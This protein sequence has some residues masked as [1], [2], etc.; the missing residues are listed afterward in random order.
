MAPQFRSYVWDPALILS[1][2]MLMQAVYYSSLGLWLALVDSLVQNSPSLDQIFSYEV[3]NSSLVRHE[4]QKIF[5]AKGEFGR[6]ENKHCRLIS[7]LSGVATFDTQENP[8]A[9]FFKKMATIQ[10]PSLLRPEREGSR[11]KNTTG[12]GRKMLD[13]KKI[14]SQRLCVSV[15]HFSLSLTPGSEVEK[16]E[17]KLW[18]IQMIQEGGHKYSSTLSP[19][20]PEAGVLEVQM[21][22]WN[23]SHTC[24]ELSVNTERATWSWKSPASASPLF[25]FSQPRLLSIQTV[26]TD[27]QLLCFLIEKMERWGPCSCHAYDRRQGYKSVH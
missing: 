14:G 9:R 13:R 12:N 24:G 18:V 15:F 20:S 5:R 4:E 3:G 11:I 26:Y 16:S 2:I 22:S 27:L 7:L 6:F 21:S 23:T 8:G 19:S 10:I 1:Q 25:F 17:Y